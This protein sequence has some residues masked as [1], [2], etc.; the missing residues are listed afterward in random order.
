MPELTITR[1][2]DAPR[3]LVYAAWTDPDQLA[4]W[5]GPR[6]FTGSAVTVDARPGGLWRACITSPDGEE[7]WMRG[8]Y[9]ELDPPS[10]IVFGFV[11]ET[12]G[13][14]RA[15]TLVSIGFADVGGKTE[16][17]F[18]QRGFPTTEDRDGHHTG[19]TECFARLAG[20]LHGKEPR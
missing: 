16:M 12:E 1:L 3:E 15:E 20:H 10:R 17:T 8:V 4:C 14:L 6:G 18:T 13:D 2:F 9:R 5:L 19:W 11:W 7:H